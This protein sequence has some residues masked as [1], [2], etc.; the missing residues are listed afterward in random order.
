M[1]VA[2]LFA[3]IGG[4]E[5]GLSRAGHHTVMTCEVWEPAVNV[6]ADRFDGVPNKPDVRK[7]KSLPKKVDL[8]SAGFPCQ[9]LSQ[10]GNTAGIAGKKSGL[11]DHVFRL[12]DRRKI[13][14][15]VLENVSFMLQLDKGAAMGRLT[16]A[17]EERGY[18][19]AYRTINTQ[20]FL[21]QRR[22]RVFFVASC[23]DLVP[24]NVLFED[25][26][27]PPKT[28]SKLTSRAHGFYW[29]EGTRGLGWADDAI[30][31]LKN[32]STIG[33][34]SPPAILLPNGR[35]IKPDIRDA[36]RLQGFPENW[37][38]S[39][40]M[41]AR[42]SLVGNAVS[43][44]V[45]EWLGHRIAGPGFYFGEKDTAWP[46]RHSWPRAAYYDGTKRTAVAIGAF[47]VWK[48]REPLHKFLKHEG[49][50]LS[51][52]ATAGFLGRAEKSGLRFV[53]GFLDAVRKHL[54]RME[55]GVVPKPPKKPT[56]SRRT[57]NELTL[58]LL[59]AAE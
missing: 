18:R 56:I 4:L 52:R 8:L 21:P 37:T 38:K 14:V 40:E 6:L 57:K 20:S 46:K 31:T 7:L 34:P 27:T 12:L 19:W 51:P 45:A 24:Q 25:E 2:A 30:P 43:V 53:P 54:K 32:G 48:K 13:P 41:R 15:V 58:P 42:W 22:E 49:T 55:L 33:I 17:F 39:A 59:I 5:L 16:A 28:V 44:P 36:E 1:N 29:T 10:A 11:I 50:L 47:P 35:L 3:G 23:S 26:V 9:D